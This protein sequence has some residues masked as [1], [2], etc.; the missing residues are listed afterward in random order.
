MMINHKIITIKKLS[1]NVINQSY[2]SSVD[3]SDEFLKK[4][5]IVYLKMDLN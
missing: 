4:L 3:E 2:C 1:L 5:Q